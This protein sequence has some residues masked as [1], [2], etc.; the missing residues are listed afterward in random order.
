MTKTM[1]A[2]RPGNSGRAAWADKLELEL[3]LV[4][5]VPRELV[6]PVLEEAAEAVAE[7]GQPAEELF[8]PAEEYAAAVA[9]ERI[10]AGYRSTR[11]SEG[12][13][14]VTH[15]RQGMVAGGIAV[16]IMAAA[17]TFGDGGRSGASVLLLALSASVLVA[18]TFAVFPALRT[19]GRTRTA[20]LCGSGA[21]G[22]A[23]AGICL[24]SLPSIRD[25]HSFLF[26]PLAAGGFGLLLG[27]LGPAIPARVVSRW[28]SPCEG[29]Q[30]DDEQ[31]LRRLGE[32][33]YGRHG[34]PLRTAQQHVGEAR[35]HLAATGRLAQQ[36]LGQVE[37]YAMNLTDGPVREVRL[38]RRQFLGA[39]CS[40]AVFAVLFTLTLTDPDRGGAA[41]WVPAVLFVCSGTLA[42]SFLRKMK[43]SVNH[44]G[45]H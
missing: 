10:D 43:A 45:Q 39:C 38:A 9:T 22:I 41:L 30:L 40:T 23:A 33:L 25:A 32:L 29:R 14:P 44:V 17:G 27:A 37:I 36:E 20:W 19:A 4:H 5:R 34:L 35:E 3:L 26:P 8:G 11:D 13:T 21:V 18:M 24:A 1:A 12:G 42:V 31:W 15:F 7:T 28:F 6:N 16:L 2:T